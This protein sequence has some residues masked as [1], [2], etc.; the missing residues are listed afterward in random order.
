MA[1]IKFQGVEKRFGDVVVVEDLDFTIADREFFTFVGPSG[2]VQVRKG[3]IH[4]EHPGSPDDG[5]PQSYA[6]SLPSG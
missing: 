3:L 2:C 6:L 5:P 4:Q 1:K